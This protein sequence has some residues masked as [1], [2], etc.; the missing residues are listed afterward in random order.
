MDSFLEP[1]E[2]A[3]PCRHWY[4]GSHLR[5]LVARGPHAVPWPFVPFTQTCF[6]PQHTLPGFSTAHRVKSPGDVGGKVG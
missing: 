3:W 1:P 6:H 5:T 4:T 2:G